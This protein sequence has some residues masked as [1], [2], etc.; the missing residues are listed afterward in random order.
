MQQLSIDFAPRVR[1]ARKLGGEAMEAA[2]EKARQADPT[3]APR[4]V[5]FIERFMRDLGPGQTIHGEDLTNAI[6]GA[7][8]VPANDDR[9]FGGVFVRARHAKLIV[10]VGSAPRL[11]GHG[12]AGGRIYAAGEGAR[13]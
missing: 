1:F 5:A 13:A 7:G 10:Q 11:K 8:I 6:K 4:A 12:T 9:A 2:L 3:F